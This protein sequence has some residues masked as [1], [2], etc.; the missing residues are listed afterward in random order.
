METL[1]EILQEVKK[2][3]NEVNGTPSQLYAALKG[4]IGTMLMSGTITKYQTVMVC[5]YMIKLYMVVKAS[6]EKE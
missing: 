3:A 2:Q 4:L 1:Q 6:N 5:A